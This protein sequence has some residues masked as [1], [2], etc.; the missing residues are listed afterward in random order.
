MAK[1][2]KS[3]PELSESDKLRFYAKIDKNGPTQP[4]METACWVWTGSR[5]NGGYGIFWITA[6]HFKSH[7]IAFVLAGGALEG[8]NGYALHRCDYRSCVNP[9]HLK[10]GTYADNATDRELRGRSNNLRGDSHPARTNPERL[11]RGDAHYSRTNPEKL[12]RGASHGSK[13]RPDR[14]PS[15][16]RHGSKTHPERVARGERNGKYTKPECTL[17]GEQNGSAKL[18]L[19][20]VTT[21]RSLYAAGGLSQR[22]IARN[23]NVSQPLIGKIIKRDLWA[24]VA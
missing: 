5:D 22:D 7:R 20:D 1:S 9:S 8:E 11:S 6:G 24:H 13:T 21:I 23:Y 12:A 3:I 18:S 16:D 15:G 17:R 10:A 14:V 4:H 19:K 2:A